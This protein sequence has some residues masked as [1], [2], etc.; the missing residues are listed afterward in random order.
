MTA[1][2]QK[3]LKRYK[4]KTMTKE[5]EIL[6]EKYIAEGRLDLNDFEELNHINNALDDVLL[7][8]T[9]RTMDMKFYTMLG[10]QKAR[11]ERKDWLKIWFGNLPP[12]LQYSLP[13][14]LIFFVVLVVSLW[15]KTIFVK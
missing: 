1:D 13:V 7:I 11:S 2:I 10:E 6:L 3:L 8:D 9:P 4:D 12:V 5:D 15:L 14:F